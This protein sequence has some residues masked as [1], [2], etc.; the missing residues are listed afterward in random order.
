MELG[1]S[2]GAHRADRGGGIV[3]T[4]AGVWRAERV[5]DRELCASWGNA[6]SGDSEGRRRRDQGGAVFACWRLAYPSVQRRW[7]CTCMQSA[8]LHAL[9]KATF[10]NRSLSPFIPSADR[11]WNLSPLN[12]W[13]RQFVDQSQF[14]HDR[15][16]HFHPWLD[17]KEG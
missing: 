4:V 5:T 2:A 14:G 7:T 8:L 16:P 10:T 11:P 9:R 15:K 1:R 6:F 12:E 17:Y 13:Y 3:R